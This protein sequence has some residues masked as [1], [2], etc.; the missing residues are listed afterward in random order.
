MQIAALAA[1]AR[2]AG[3]LLWLLLAPAAQG[4]RLEIAIQH[5]FAGEAL[6][7][8]SLRYRNAAGETL[9]FTRLS[10]LLSGFALE[11]SDGGWVE[12]P[13]QVAWIDAGQRRQTATLS[14]VPE[15]RYRAIRFSVGVDPETNNGDPARSAADHPL[16]PILNGLHWSWQSGYIF[17]A[18]EGHYRTAAGKASGY[19]HHFARSENRTTIT[20]SV[21]LDL[22]QDAGL[23]IDFDLAALLNAPRQI[24]F[25]RDGETTHSREGDPVAAAYVANLPGAMQVREVRSSLPALSLPSAVL[26]LY[27]P[28]KFTPYRFRMSRTFPVP[29]LPRDNP[30]IVERVALGEALFHE[31]ALSRD[32][33]ISCASCHQRDAGLSD[34]RPKSI[35]VAGKTGAR[36][37]MPLFNLAWKSSFFWDGRAKS[38]REQVLIPIQDHREMDET[39]ERVVD[40]L[41]QDSRYRQLFAAAFGTP[42]ITSEK[43]GLALEQFLFTLTSREAKFDQV[44][45]GKGTFTPNEQRGFELFMTENDPRTGHRGADCF[46]CHGGPLFTD[47]QFHNN[48]IA[49][50]A[51]D[52]GRSG[53][54]GLASDED[55][56]ATPSLRNVSRTAPYMHDGRFATLAEV[57]DHYSEGI[58]P[59]V[60][61]DPNLAKHAT[62]GLHLSAEDK[63]ALLAF[64]ETLTSDSP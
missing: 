5:S 14:S 33:S 36:N 57:V 28:E 43:L 42:E 60:T 55:K 31:R 37:S 62:G 32:S 4:A 47:H 29:D 26:P 20:L 10:Y 38:L 19:V 23:L 39:L 52:R 9:S 53:V 63:S 7:L 21:K 27:L 56:F 3:V 44:L 16:N 40:K 12:L 1:F 18:V 34:P 54:T 48:G 24:S 2:N 15:E 46:H 59:G 22:R 13:W 41:T 11:K 30:L 50:L 51:A 6:R 45:R 61:L 49:P 17:L 25:A 8:D 58:Q 64:L 35:G